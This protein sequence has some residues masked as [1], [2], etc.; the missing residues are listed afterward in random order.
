VIDQQKL[1]KISGIGVAES[2]RARTFRVSEAS[3]IFLPPPARY[4]AAY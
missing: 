1:A 3:Q 4:T 2:R